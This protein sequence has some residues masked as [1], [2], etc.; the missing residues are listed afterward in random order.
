MLLLNLAR[1]SAAVAITL[2]TTRTLATTINKAGFK[3]SKDHEWLTI[4]DN[5]AT[6][7]I[8]NFAQDTLG[9]IVYVELPEEGV[10]FEIGDEIGIIESVK[11]VSNIIAPITGTVVEVNEQLS[12]QPDL[13]NQSPHDEGWIC[14]VQIAD[15]NELN[16]LMNEDEYETF[17]QEEA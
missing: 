4:S 13:V 9:D 3:Y 8:S 10:E 7:G 17:C 15:T 1:R 2:P 16:D 14:K 12:E 6:M 11:S 5:V